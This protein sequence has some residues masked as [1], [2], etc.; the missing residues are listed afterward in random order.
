MPDGLCNALV[1]VGVLAALY[2][3][4]FVTRNALDWDQSVFFGINDVGIGIGV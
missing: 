3:L 2:S 4:P 1:S